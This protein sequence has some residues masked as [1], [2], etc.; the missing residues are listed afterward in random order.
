MY[1]VLT[2]YATFNSMYNPVYM[3]RDFESAALVSFCA[4]HTS[5]INVRVTRSIILP[6]DV[7][8]SRVVYTLVGGIVTV[9][10][11]LCVRACVR[12]CVCVC[13]RA[14]GTILLPS[15]QSI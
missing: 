10:R 15:I 2:A 1:N 9:Y 7:L 6:S 5:S 11:H 4:S 8:S 3:I 12:A 14:R 13:V